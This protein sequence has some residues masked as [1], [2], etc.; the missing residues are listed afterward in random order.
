M[1]LY[2]G[3]NFHFKILIMILEN[4]AQM[5]SFQQRLSSGALHHVYPP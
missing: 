3:Y 1:I 2:L 4:A 5:Q